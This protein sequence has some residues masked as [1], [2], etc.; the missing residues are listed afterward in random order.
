M[1]DVSPHNP[2]QQ[3]DQGVLYNYDEAKIAPYTLPDPLVGTDGTKITDA[4]AW[5]ANR[6]SELLHLFKS[7]VYGRSPERPSALRFQVDSTDPQALGGRATR[8]EIT[9][10]FT[11]NQ[12]GPK[13]HLLLYLPNG[14]KGPA[15]AF[16]GLNFQGNQTVSTDPGITLPSQW[17][18]EDVPSPSGCLK[19]QAD[20]TRG[21]EAECW[22][23]EKIVSRGYAFA[24][25]HYGDLEPDFVGGCKYGVRGAFGSE[26]ALQP[27]G[28]GAIAAW[29][30]GLSRALDY[31]EADPDIDPK[32]IAVMGHSRL[33]K[34]AL[35]AGATDERFALVISNES[36]EGGAT[37]SRRRIGETVARINNAFPHWFCGNF[38]QY[39][40]N[41]DALPIDQHELIALIAP[42]AVYIA[43]AEDDRW[44][45]PRGEFL[46][47]KN[48]EPVYALLGKPGL[49]IADMPETNR[50]VGGFIGYH[51]RSGA[52][53]VTA[54]DWTQFL[55]F[56]DRHLNYSFR[57]P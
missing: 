27:E 41:E 34:A 57:T 53:T 15:P 37:L 25:A 17:Q 40:D 24:T 43:S 10:S 14:A 18:Q 31:L 49:G 22:Q 2:A 28:W 54:F 26:E 46:G 13:M 16:L 8:K 33:G 12:D 39:D 21:A 19:R 7:Q 35:W 44:A 47:A 52:H 9:I 1:E 51:I 36:G 3:P 50:S 55:A 11:G 23:V 30:W 56:A 6:R 48:A 42:R 29:A 32:R 4:Q 20:S 5:I 45:D 38:K